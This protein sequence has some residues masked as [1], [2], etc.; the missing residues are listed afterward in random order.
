M[1]RWVLAAL[2]YGVMYI[3]HLGAAAVIARLEE[4]TE[5]V[6]H[7]VARIAEAR[8]P[9]VPGTA[10]FLTRTLRDAPPVMVWHVRH[11]RAA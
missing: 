6:D 5:P 4:L 1:C 2:V 3:W 10:V 9:R 8:I 7:F 11:N